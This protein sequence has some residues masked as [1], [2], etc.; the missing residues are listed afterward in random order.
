MH[1]VGSVPSNWSIVGQRDFNGD[2]MT[3]L[4]WRDTSG[5]TAIWFMNGTQVLSSTGIASLDSTWSVV[6]T[7]DFN[8][9]GMGDILWE[10][11]GG[12]LAVWLM[13]GATPI[14]MAALGAIPLTYSV[15]EPVTSTA[16][17][18]PTFSGATR[19]AIRRSGS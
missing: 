16:T 12:N 10:D 9:D 4:L 1:G 15:L 18:S 8:G 5:D 13:N 14:S 11:T 17:A 7:G 6:A 3:D 2:G 19:A